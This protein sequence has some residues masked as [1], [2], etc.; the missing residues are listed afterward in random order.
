MLSRLPLGA[1]AKGAGIGT[2]GYLGG[3]LAA[4]AFGSETT[5]GKASSVLGNAAGMAGTGAMIGSVIPGIGTA[6]GAIAG[7]VLGAG[8]GIYDKFFGKTSNTVAPTTAATPAGS[9]ATAATVS[10]VAQGGQQ[11]VN[12]NIVGSIPLNVNIEKVLDPLFKLTRTPRQSPG[13][14]EFSLADINDEITVP[15]KISAMSEGFE[16]LFKSMNDNLYAIARNT[17]PSL[18]NN[19]SPSSAGSSSAVSPLGSSL[20]DAMVSVESSGNTN[21]VSKK[22]ATGLM[23]VLPST[24]MK[25]GFGMPDIFEFAKFSGEKTAANAQSLLKNPEIGKPYGDLYMQKMLDRYNGNLEHALIAYNWGP[26]NADK[27]LKQGADK[28][29]LPEETRNYIKKIDKLLGNETTPYASG[30]MILGPGTPTSDSIPAFNKDTGQS[31]ALSTG[32]YVL[33]ANV[34]KILG[35]SYLDNLISNPNALKRETGGIIPG[36]DSELARKLGLIDQVLNEAGLKRE[37][38]SLN[39][40]KDISDGVSKSVS[41]ESLSMIQNSLSQIN[42]FAKKHNLSIPEST[43]SRSY[44]NPNSVSDEDFGVSSSLTFAEGGMIP[45]NKADDKQRELDKL[46]AN[47]DTILGS[48]TGLKRQ[49]FSLVEDSSSGIIG[50]RGSMAAESKSMIEATLAKAEDISKRYNVLPTPDPVPI[51]KASDVTDAD[52]GVSSEMAMPTSNDASQFKFDR[53]AMLKDTETFQRQQGENLGLSSSQL[54]DPMREAL[55]PMLD[56]QDATNQNMLNVLQNMLSVLESS[57]SIQS[58]MLNY[59]RM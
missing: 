53:A 1:M 52:F 37:G 15:V 13:M 23:Q 44:V 58:N 18:G 36:A 40:V 49:G 27:W 29:K 16:N 56:K 8:Y 6:A 21:A 12:V 38:S 57:T 7:G 32:E 43:F 19:N 45:G 20:S 59:A 35:K 17:V 47:I 22:G 50:V 2:V 42:E 11:A 41:K 9:S 33:P 28:S 54:V 3:E 25:P 46:I 10:T 4:S 24:A 39:I 30:G 34:T 31:I 48:G 14:S 51:I 55:T 26:G 5:A